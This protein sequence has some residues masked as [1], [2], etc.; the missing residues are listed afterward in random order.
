MQRPHDLLAS[1]NLDALW[2]LDTNRRGGLFCLLHAPQQIKQITHSR[3]KARPTTAQSINL[4]LTKA[5][6]TKHNQST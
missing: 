3:T 6:P 4:G 2:H 5:R 1:G